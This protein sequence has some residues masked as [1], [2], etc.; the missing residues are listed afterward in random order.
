MTNVMSCHVNTQPVN[1]PSLDC[2]FRGLDMLVMDN[3]Q[4]TGLGMLEIPTLMILYGYVDTRMIP[5]AL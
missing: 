5:M 2:R 3:G 4:W 1:P